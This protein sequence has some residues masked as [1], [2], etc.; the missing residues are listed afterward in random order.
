VHVDIRIGIINSPREINLESSQSSAD[1]EAVVTSAI[2]SEAKFFRLVDQK[3]NVYVVPLA[4]F[5]Y[6]E[7]GSEESR[8]VGFV[9]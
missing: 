5:G 2:E 9:S 7:I 1:V 8:R 6:L 3:G 4:T